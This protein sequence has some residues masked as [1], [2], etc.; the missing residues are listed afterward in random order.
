MRFE[1][2]SV[3]LPVTL[4]GTK[5]RESPCPENLGTPGSWSGRRPLTAQGKCLLPQ[6]D[7]GGSWA[8]SRAQAPA[9]FQKVS[10]NDLGGKSSPRSALAL[11]PWPCPP[12]LQPLAEVSLPGRPP[13]SPR[14]IHIVCLTG[15]W[16]CPWVVTGDAGHCAARRPGDNVVMPSSGSSRQME[17]S[18]E[19][20]RADSAGIG[21]LT[22]VTLREP[23]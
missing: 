12:V 8:G 3:P 10:M 5:H 13:G 21:Q 19:Q 15:P 11:S 18:R 9:L 7:R 1:L 6:R 17:A 16:E 22:P 20:G 2:R 23:R 4:L 14:P